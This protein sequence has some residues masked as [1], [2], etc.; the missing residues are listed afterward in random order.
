MW[1]GVDVAYT[2]HGHYMPG[3]AK[4]G[5][6]PI[7]RSECGGVGMCS[8]CTREAE[9]YMDNYGTMGDFKHF[10]HP[11][12]VTTTDGQVVKDFTHDMYKFV[13]SVQGL[14]A[15][16]APDPQIKAKQIVKDFIDDVHMREFK[17]ITPGYEIYVIWFSKV[18]KNWKA[19]IS[20]NLEDEMHYEVTYNGEKHETYLDAY[21]KRKNIVIP[22]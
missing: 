4:I 10:Q 20:T 3:T 15:G 8:S 17:G 9:L 1:T 12:V 14:S 21:K 13:E 7:N 5:P 6:E 22:D 11:Q 18:L 19:L 16:H 2:R